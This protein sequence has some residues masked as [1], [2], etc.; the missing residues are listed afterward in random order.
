MEEAGQKLKRARERLN[1]RYRDVEESQSA[2][3]RA[4]QNDEFIMG[5]SARLVGQREQGH[6]SHY[7]SALYSLCAIYRLDLAECWSWLGV[8]L[9]SAGGGFGATMVRDRPDPPHRLPAGQ[10]GEVLLPISLDPRHRPCRRH[11]LPEPHDP[12]LGKTAL[13]AAERNGPE[14]PALRLCG[15]EDWSMYPLLQPGSLECVIDETRAQSRR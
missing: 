8:D 11:H 12:A 3:R 5:A 7:I 15:D 10:R 1:L 2:H 9:W 13:D 6:R 4:P 14:E